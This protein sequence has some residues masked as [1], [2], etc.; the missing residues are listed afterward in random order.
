MEIGQRR[1]YSKFFLKYS[2]KGT[3]AGYCINN[4]SSL[5]EHRP[6]WNKSYSNNGM[7]IIL[8][9]LIS[10]NVEMENLNVH[11]F[12]AD[13]YLLSINRDSS[14]RDS[15]GSHRNPYPNSRDVGSRDCGR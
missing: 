13:N 11:R 14:N 15:G 12:T 8:S 9:P 5:K 6:P 7:K 2:M 1:L 3:A 4:G 10:P